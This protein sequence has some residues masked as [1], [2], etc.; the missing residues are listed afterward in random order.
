[1]LN[2]RSMLG[3][4]LGGL[5]GLLGL[6]KV[7]ASEF[8]VTETFSLPLPGDP[9]VVDTTSMHNKEWRTCEPALGKPLLETKV[10]E[11]DLLEIVHEGGPHDGYPTFIKIDGKMLGGPNGINAKPRWEKSIHLQTVADEPL[12][13]S[14][15]YAN[16]DVEIF[17]PKRFDFTLG[18]LRIQLHPDIQRCPS[19]ITLSG[20][21][22]RVKSLRLSFVE[23]E[24]CWVDLKILPHKETQPCSEPS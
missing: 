14:A 11:V 4:L 9:W 20:H 21:E 10:T 22:P 23:G 5:A 3:R 2:R 7:G 19:K 18:D 12:Q 24:A 15:V 16:G 13:V 6:G 1:M 17:L 8:T